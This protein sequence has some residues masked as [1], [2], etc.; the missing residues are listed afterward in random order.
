MLEYRI[1]VM[2]TY[3]ENHV[4]T[5]LAPNFLLLKKNKGFY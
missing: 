4:T 3:Q 1:L 5:I 2:D